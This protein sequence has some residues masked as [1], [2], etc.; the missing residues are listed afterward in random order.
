MMLTQGFPA[1]LLEA[2]VPAEAVDVYRRHGVTMAGGSTAFYIAFLNE[3]RKQPGDADRSRRLR[4]LSGGGAPKPPELFFEV[5]ARDRR[6]G[7]A[8]ATA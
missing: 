5:Q 8:T 1:V 2:F 4:M 7:R 3:Q 6:A